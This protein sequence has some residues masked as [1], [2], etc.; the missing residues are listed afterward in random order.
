[1]SVRTALILMLSVLTAVVAGTLSYAAQ[2][3]AAEAV[4]Y[5]LTAAAASIMFFNKVIDG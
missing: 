2:A 5:A 3:S 1:M 4:L